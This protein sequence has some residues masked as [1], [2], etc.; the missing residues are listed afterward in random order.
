VIF[1]GKTPLVQAVVIKALGALQNLVVNLIT[2]SIRRI[3]VDIPLDF[4]LACFDG[5]AQINGTCSDAGGIIKLYFTKVFK[6]Y[7]NCGK[8]TNIKVE[9]LG[10]WATLYLTDLLSIHKIKILG[11]SRIIIDWLN[12]KSALL[13]TSLEGWKQ[14]TIMLANKFLVVQFIHIFR[15]FN[16]EADKLSKKALLAPE[17]IICLQLW[18]GDSTGLHRHI[19]IY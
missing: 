16:K 18:T 15:E 9:L 6:W 14:R 1:E 12:H 19:S 2:S 7:F 3:R 17:G 10:A 11:D 8:G 4:P 13:V 5:T